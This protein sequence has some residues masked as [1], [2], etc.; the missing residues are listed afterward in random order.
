[1]LNILCLHGPFTIFQ[2]NP[3]QALVTYQPTNWENVFTG[4]KVECEST[5]VRNRLPSF[6]SYFFT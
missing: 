2:A 1:M 6:I 5:T 4:E 3:S